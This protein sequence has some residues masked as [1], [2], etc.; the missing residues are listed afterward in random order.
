MRVINGQEMLSLLE[1]AVAE[2]GDSYVYP[3]LG[4]CEYVYDPSD[5]EYQDEEADP[6]VAAFGDQVQPACAVGLALSYKDQILLDYIVDA[7]LN[8][9]S[10]H[11]VS[12]VLNSI[13]ALGVQFTVKAQRMAGAMQYAQDRGAT[14][15]EGLVL[16]KEIYAEGDE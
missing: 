14:W 11:E 13:P 10:I 6:I 15:G 5:Y 9:D 16:A 4:H 1:M 7:G 12:D 2:R 8:G 3:D